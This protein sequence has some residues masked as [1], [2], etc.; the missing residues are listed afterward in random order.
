MA[1][2]TLAVALVG[3]AATVL[4]QLLRELRCER[5][6]PDAV[7][8]LGV[9]DAQDV[10]DQVGVPPAER[11]EKLS[12]K[13]GTLSN[14]ISNL[15]RLE[16]E[17]PDA[18]L[19]REVPADSG[20]DDDGR[21]IVPGGNRSG[22][23]TLTLGREERMSDWV[24]E[25]TRGG[26]PAYGD[27][28]DPEGFS[29][30]RAIIAM[31]TGRWADAETE[32]R[33]LSETALGAGGYLLP[34]PIAGFVIDRIRPQTRVLQAGAS[35]VPMENGTLAIPR[36]TG[37]VTA[38][39]R[40]E[41]SPV[42]ESDPVFD[43]VQLVA[44]SL[45]VL[46]RLSSEL[47]EDLTAQ[48]AGIIELELHRALGAELDR[49]A[50]RGSGAGAEPR[51]IRGTTGVTVQAFGGA[52]G[53]A[54]T[55]YL[56]LTDAAAAVQANGFTPN[57][58]IIS[59]R[60]NKEYGTFVDSVG[61]PLQR[62]PLLDGLTLLVSQ[63][64]PETLTVGTSTDTSEAYTAQ[65]DQLLIGVRPE[66]GVRIVRSNERYID[67]LQTALVAYVRADVAVAHASAFCVTTGLR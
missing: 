9:T 22:P 4:P 24:Q 58:A 64:V 44:K 62:P 13:I 49:V 39:W 23:P 55:S 30:G 14:K 48:G 12:G 1:K 11:L 18:P 15:E 66:I 54:P 27:A 42:A 41:N 53:A 31:A 35:L 29:V 7:L 51:G 26:H 38:G 56:A 21:P 20:Y 37:G 34:A 67:Q 16:R 61:Q 50:L 57:A 40:A 19:R 28:S 33:A 32:Q 63:N 36:L 43:R 60:S 6:R 17:N 46:V 5:D 2:D 45:A 59:P 10:L 3:R 8:R 65:W 47:L 52:N 25:R